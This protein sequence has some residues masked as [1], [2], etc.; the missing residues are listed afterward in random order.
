M[1]K[2]PL[3]PSIAPSDL[4]HLQAMPTGGGSDNTL[5]KNIAD[6][7]FTLEQ[8]LALRPVTWNWKDDTLG[9]R[10]EYGFV[11]QELEKELPDLVYTDVW[12][13]GTKRKFISSQALLP[14]L[15]AAIQEL[16][17]EIDDLKSQL[18]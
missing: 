3:S 9:A 15:V 8:V 2:L 17:S 18:E 6:L 10:Q 5:K 11:A 4:V 12:V 7:P 1:N 16:Q 13:D 14:Y